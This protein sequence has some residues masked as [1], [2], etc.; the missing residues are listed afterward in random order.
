MPSTVLTTLR[1]TRPRIFARSRV[2]QIHFWRKLLAI[3]GWREN[4]YHKKNNLQHL[5][6]KRMFERR[7]SLVGSGWV[8]HIIETLCAGLS[9]SYLYSIT[10]IFSSDAMEKPQNLRRAQKKNNLGNSS[11]M[12]T[13]RFRGLFWERPVSIWGYLME[14]VD[15]SKPAHL[16]RKKSFVYRSVCCCRAPGLHVAG[17]NLIDTGHRIF[18]GLGMSGCSS[19]TLINQSTNQTI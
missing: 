11:S 16:P 17:I 14:I 2:Q 12:K 5:V 9:R 1:G 18:F 13:N 7:L 19:H 15:V 6:E 10:E 8:R 4:L 3:F